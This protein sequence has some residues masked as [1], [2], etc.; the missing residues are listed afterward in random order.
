LKQHRASAPIILVGLKAD[1]KEAS[2]DSSAAEKLAEEIGGSGYMECS[3]KTSH[4]H[5]F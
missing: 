3:A 4:G 2:F 1:L 5:Y